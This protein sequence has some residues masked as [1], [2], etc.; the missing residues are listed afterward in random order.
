MTNRRKLR[1]KRGNTLVEFAL[2]SVLLVPLM[3]GTVNVGLTLG[4]SIQ[5]T[6]VSRDAGHMYVRQ[7]DFSQ[8]PN[9]K[10]I[11]RIA[12]GLNFKL[13]G[14]GDGVVIL[15]KIQH[16]G[17]TECNSTNLNGAPCSNLG[18]SVAIQR[19]VIGNKS[20]KQSD[21]AKP[22]EN[23]ILQPSGNIAPTDYLTKSQCVAT[24]LP[25]VLNMQPGELAYVAESFFAAP[26]WS[27]PGSY[28]HTGSYARSIF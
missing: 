16:I 25:G 28:P 5:T 24:G 18:K 2:I 21:V 3:L 15:T 6:Q 12:E 22:P 26:S 7:V 20:L 10:I 13:D 8:T 9:Q 14:T 27:F 11:E 19:L 4:R 17:T 1:S 23:L